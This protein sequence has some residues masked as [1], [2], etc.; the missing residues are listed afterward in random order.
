VN[1]AFRF[2][3]GWEISGPPDTVAAV[4]ADLGTYPRWWPQILAVASLGP[5][6]ARVLCR[7]TLPYTL[8]LVLTAARRETRVLETTI[9]GDLE[10]RV[11]WVV[12]PAQGGTWLSWEQEVTV[13]GVLGVASY[14]ARPL[15][16]WNHRRMMA[17]GIA[18]LRREVARRLA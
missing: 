6:Q 10:G 7:S 1:A 3:G 2:T 12:A 4:L 8:D 16:T 13:D 14:V 17:D 11:R 18:G 15:L 5:D 9:G